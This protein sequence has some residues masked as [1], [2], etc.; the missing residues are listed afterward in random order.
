MG[1]T[2]AG[3]ALLSYR[4]SEGRLKDLGYKIAEG[5]IPAVNY[6]VPAYYV[7]AT[8]EACASLARF[9]GIRYGLAAGGAETP[10][11]LMKNSRNEGFGD[12]VKLRILL[13]TYVLRSGFQDR[14]YHRAQKIRTAILNDFNK[15]F[16][17]VDALMMPVFP[18]AAFHHGAS[19]MTQ[20]QQKTADLYT[21]S[22]NLAGLPA[23]AVPSSVEN[24]L[25]VGVQFTAPAFEEERLFRISER[26]ENLFPMPK[27]RIYSKEWDV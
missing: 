7:I 24:G 14:Y 22:A 4:K 16:N 3:Q 2:R 21:C 26:L 5:E 17:S 20:L 13:G 18:T 6:A 15:I 27:P 25:P 19:D 10:S 1:R 12:E 8:A 23:L 9:N 11:D